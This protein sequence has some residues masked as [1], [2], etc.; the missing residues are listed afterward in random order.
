MGFA[1]SAAGKG[2]TQPGAGAGAGVNRPGFS[3]PWP[4]TGS[5]ICTPTE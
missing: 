4:L 5:E 3:A 2:H 1:R